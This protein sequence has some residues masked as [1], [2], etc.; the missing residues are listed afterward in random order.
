[1]KQFAKLL[2]YVK[3]LQSTLYATAYPSFHHMKLG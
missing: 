3:R 2:A 1:M